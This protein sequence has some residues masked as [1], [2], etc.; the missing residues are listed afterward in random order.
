MVLPKLH[1]SIK[2]PS[3]VV[4]TMFDQQSLLLKPALKKGGYTGFEL[5]VS[6]S[7]RLSQFH[8]HSISLEQIDR[9]LPNFVY[10][11]I[12]TRSRLGLLHIII[13]T[14]VIELWHLCKNFV[15]NFI[16]AQ[17]LENETI[18]SEQILYVHWY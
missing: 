14:L 4:C 11:F 12:L 1:V 15:Q 8:F 2:M 6:P 3:G 13:C 7:V 10:A 16:S 18:E 9:I 5:S 17:Y